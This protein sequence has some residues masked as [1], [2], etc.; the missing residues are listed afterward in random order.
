MQ[1]DNKNLTYKTKCLRIGFYLRCASQR[2]TQCVCIEVNYSELNY[3]SNVINHFQFTFNVL[4]Y[5]VIVFFI[6]HFN[7]F[8]LN[9]L[10]VE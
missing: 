9:L 3:Y 10:L 4:I 1:N 5:C 6:Y 8:L 2:A 7:F